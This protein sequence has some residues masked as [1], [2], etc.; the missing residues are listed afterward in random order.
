M[1]PLLIEWLLRGRRDRR[2]GDE[3]QAVTDIEQ[4][5]ALLPAADRKSQAR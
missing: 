1:I 2:R 3:V 5:R 4:L